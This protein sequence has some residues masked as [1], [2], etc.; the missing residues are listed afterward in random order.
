MKVWE[1]SCREREGGREGKRE[2]GRICDGRGWIIILLVWLTLQVQS[3]NL[4]SPFLSFVNRSSLSSLSFIPI[5][6]SLFQ[7]TRHH[8]FS[9]SWYYVEERRKTSMTVTIDLTDSNSTWSEQ[10]SSHHLI[11]HFPSLFFPFVSHLFFLILFSRCF[12][13]QFAWREK[14]R[15]KGRNREGKSKN[16][17]QSLTGCDD[18]ISFLTRH[19]Y[20]RYGSAVG[21]SAKTKCE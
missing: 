7:A 17:G 5:F 21:L 2:G 4:L 9:Q 6:P 16:S 15:A 12:I 10:I 20:H 14:E 8:L 1:L 19:H 11:F 13:D 18:S 3:K